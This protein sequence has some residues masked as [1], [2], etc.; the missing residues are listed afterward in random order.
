MTT[1]STHG[2]ATPDSAGTC[3]PATRV[4]R[5]LLG[6]GVLAG[7]VY[8]T[9]SLIQAV[10]RPGFDLSRHEWS[11]L[12]NGPHGWIQMTNL[13]VTGAMVLAFAVGLRRALAGGQGARWAPRLVGVYG[14]SL[15]AAAAFR[16]DPAFGFPAGTPAG[17]GAV[18]WHGT[19]HL[20]SGAVGFTALAAACFVIARRYTGEGRRAP[21]NLARA[22]GIIFL[23][24]FGAVA[25]GAGRPAANLAFT[26][27]VI[28]VWAWLAVMAADR[29][30]T[31][32]AS[33][34]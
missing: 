24:G 27:A 10:T 30:R 12:A 20:L 28:I 3:D 17:P 9:A 26:A 15:V 18:S 19:L 29:Y 2:T 6:Y 23:L 25:A 16:A 1:T 31:A 33:H 7:P 8:V 21:A 5:S 4:T 34:Q 14:M 13:A 11:L 32:G 22:T